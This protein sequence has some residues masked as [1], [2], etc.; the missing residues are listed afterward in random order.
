M[1]KGLQVRIVLFYAR[2]YRFKS[3]CFASLHTLAKELKASQKNK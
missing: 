1:I 3:S 2:V